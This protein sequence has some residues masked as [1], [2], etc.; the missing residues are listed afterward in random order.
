[1]DAQ[2]KPMHG[3]PVIAI[4]WMCI[5]WVKKVKE[6]EGNAECMAHQVREGNGNQ[7]E[8]CRVGHNRWYN[9]TC[10]EG[11]VVYVSKC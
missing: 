3:E 4:S 8:S 10:V 2:I 7:A 9:L 5:A 11:V 1:M 6:Q